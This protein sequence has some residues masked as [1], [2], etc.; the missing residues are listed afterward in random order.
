MAIAGT[1]IY[2]FDAAGV[3]SNLG[4]GGFNPA[5]ANMLTDGT[6]DA[7]TGN[8]ASPVFS[9]ASYTFVAGDVGHWL[10]LKAG[11]DCYADAFYKVA[12]VAGGKATLSAAVGE[13]EVWGN[14]RV[15]PSTVAGIA[16][17]GTPTSI[18][19]TMD[20]SR[21]GTAILNRTD[22][23]S[24]NDSLVVTT[25]TGGFTPVMVGNFLGISAGTQAT[26]GRYEIVSYTDTNTIGIDRDCTTSTNNMTAATA[27]VG[28]AISLGTAGDDAIFEAI[29]G[30]TTATATPHIFIKSGTYTLGG[31]VTLSNDANAAAFCIAE[32]YSTFR[33]DR[34][35]GATRPVIAT[36][37]NI[38]TWN[39]ANSVLYSLSFTGTGT[40]VLSVGN[41]VLCV[42]CKTLNSR[43]AVNGAGFA[44]AAASACC[45]NC[46]GIS[47]RGH[48]IDTAAVGGIFGGYYHD[49]NK[50][51]Q[52]S[53]TSFTVDGAIFAS[54]VTAAIDN[55]IA[56][57]SQSVIKNCTLYG[58][59]AK[60]GTGF[61]VLSTSRLAYFVNNIVYG[62]TTGVAYATAGNAH[63]DDYNCYYNN[64]DD[65]T[66][67]ANWQKGA[68]D[69][70]VDP[71]FTNVQQRT[72]TT[73]TTTSGNHLVQTG[74]TFTTWGIT[75][76]T[77]YLHIV[78]GTGVTTGVYGIDSV[79]SETQ[80]TTDVT[81]TA[82]ATADKSWY[83]TTGLN[84]AVG[85]GL[86]ATG[87]PGAFPG[88]STTAYMDVG[89]VQ[90]QEP[91]GA[92]YAGT[93]GLH[94][95]ESGITRG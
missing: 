66:S 45:W 65:V 27:N 12:S 93:G 11:T 79:D 54:N 5:N 33:G 28:G 89:A 85:T 95:I 1:S 74:A 76:G 30:A 15:S 63:Y 87:F 55:D 19:F 42:D 67:A 32:G 70:A 40:S 64:T 77:H 44:F 83:I 18:T 14:L 41:N 48:G 47:Y 24:T 51:L 62:F 38:I 17:V 9:S 31:T 37:A 43:A 90:R 71:A 20:Y 26:A 23:A 84:W 6:V 75:A 94:P 73:A 22:F 59:E 80:I 58:T 3:A 4:A 78:S 25:A 36:G 72:G 8:T 53:T 52:I 29:L 88:A 10:Y 91:A 56:L 49:S 2:E 16:S 57:T 35:Q 7:D 81:L 68:N 61:D 39:G 50:G 82:D 60:A 92:A 21:G 46:E 34:P 69:I 13:A 86:K